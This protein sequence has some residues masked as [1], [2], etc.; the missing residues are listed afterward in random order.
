VGRWVYWVVESIGSVG[1]WVE[2]PWGPLGWV[3]GSRVHGSLGPLG[4]SSAP[5]VTSC[6]PKKYF[7]FIRP[8]AVSV[9]E[10]KNTEF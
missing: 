8:E 1:R 3:V 4:Q 7:A 5:S 2:G 10:I 6:Q 9:N